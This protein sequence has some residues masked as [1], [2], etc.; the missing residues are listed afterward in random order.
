[1]NDPQATEPPPIRPIAFAMFERPYEFDQQALVAAIRSRH[2]DLSVEAVRTGWWPWAKQAPVIR[3]GGEIVVL[4]SLPAPVLPHADNPIW[5]RA[6]AVWPQALA[7]GI[8]HRGHVVIA[9]IGTHAPRLQTARTLTAVAGSLIAAA[10]GPCAVAW[11]GRTARSA[12]MWSTLARSAFAPFPEAGH[13]VML[14]ID[15]VPFRSE[16]AFGA[17]TNGLA[18]FA[19]RE[20]EFETDKPDL[21]DVVTKVG[22]LAAYL[23]EHGPVLRDGDT[24]GASASERLTVRH[25]T[26][27]RFAGLAVLHAKSS[28]T[29]SG[30]SHDSFAHMPTDREAASVVGLPRDDGV[31]TSYSDVLRNILRVMSQSPDAARAEAGDPDATGKIASEVNKVQ[32]KLRDGITAGKLLP[33]WPTTVQAW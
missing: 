27:S 25:A 4:W 12:E 6:T 15:I 21:H 11:D 14:W 3:C 23:I 26:S 29:D 20:I 33:Y 32:G 9:A 5:V 22:G 16:G 7:A 31:L 2:P 18:A 10:P 28:G 8:R 1:M 24:L 30:P 17:V 13:P 19:G